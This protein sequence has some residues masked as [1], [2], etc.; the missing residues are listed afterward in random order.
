MV[1][2]VMGVRVVG[3]GVD[4]PLVL[5]D[6]GVGPRHRFGVPMGMVLIVGMLVFVL[7]RFVYV[8]MV[9]AFREVQTYAACHEDGR[10]DCPHRQDLAK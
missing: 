6:V 10:R 1:M 9:V 8:G 5:V 7:Q 2:P 3:M 4:H